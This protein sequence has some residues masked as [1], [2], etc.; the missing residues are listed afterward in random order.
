MKK[1]KKKKTKK[2]KKKKKKQ[3]KEDKHFPYLTATKFIFQFI[4]MFHST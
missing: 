1:K 4:T 2:K 3:T